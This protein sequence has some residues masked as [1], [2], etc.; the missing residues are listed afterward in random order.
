MTEQNKLST[1]QLAKK[2]GVAQNQLFAQ[3]NALGL[4]QKDNDQWVL[5]EDGERLGG[6]HLTGK[7]GQYVGMA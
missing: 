3:L 4:I 2:R 5:T 7:Y 1:T 6:V